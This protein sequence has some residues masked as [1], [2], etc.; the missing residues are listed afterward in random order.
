MARDAPIGAVLVVGGGIGGM[1]AAID[2]ADAGIKVTLVEPRTAIGGRMAQ[3]DKT[4][5]TND[6]AMCIVSPKLVHIGRHPDIEILTGTRLESLSGSAGNFRATLRKIPRYVDLARCTACGDCAK[7]CPV[8]R[9]N[10]YNRFLMPRKA[11][12]K[13]YPQAIPGAYAIEKAG[14][15]PCRLACPAGVSVQ[16]YVK[17]VAEKR[18]DEALAVIRRDNPFPAICGRV[19][20]RPCEESCRRAEVDEAIAIRDLKR[21]VADHEMA[22]GPARL[23]GPARQRKQSVAVV[24]AGPA[25]LTAAYYL[26]QE[27]YRVTV[28]EE[29]GYAGGAMASGIPHYRLP[30]DVLRWE[31][32]AILSTGIQIRYGTKLGR[33]VQLHEIKDEGFNAVFLATGAPRGILLDVD[34][35][36]LDGVLDGLT[37]LAEVNWG[38]KREVGPKVAVIGGGNT[39]I[40][41]ARM[42]LRCGASEVSVLYRRTR[43]EM[44]ADEE[45]IEEAEQEGIHMEYL[46]APVRLTGADGKVTGVE[47]LRTE[48]GEPD[49]SGRRRPVPV[50]GSEHVVPADQVLVAIGQRTDLGMLRDEDTGRLAPNGWIQANP[51]T[52]MTDLPGVFAGGDLLTGPR[53]VIEAVSAGKEAAISIHRYL[54]GESVSRGRGLDKVRA[55]ASV[56]GVA[57]RSRQRPVE[58]EPEERKHALDEVRSGLTLEQAVIEAERCLACGICCECYRCVEACKAGAIDHEDQP[59]EIEIEVGSVILA[60]G[61]EQ[62]DAMRNDEYGYGVARNVVTSLDLERLLSATGPTAGHVERPSDGRVPRRIAWIQCVGSRDQRHDQTYCSGVCCMFATK[63]AIIIKEHDPETELTVF[64]MDIRAHGK[65]FDEY[66]MRARDR[67]GVRYVRSQVSRVDEM[68]D[69]CDLSLSYVD[70]GGRHATEEFD[71][72]V[73]S[74]GL[75]PSAGVREMAGRLGVKTDEHGFCI[76]D[77][78]TPVS[79]S[80]PGVYVCGVF[81]GPKDIPETVAQASGAASFAAGGLAVSRHTLVARQELPPEREVSGEPRVGVLVCRCGIN[82]AGVVD[83]PAVVEHARSLPGVVYVDEALFSCSQDTQER[84]KAAIDQHRLDRFV[85]ASCSPRTHEPVFQQTIR[86]AGLNPF[87]FSMANIRDQCSWVHGSRPEEATDKARDLLRMAVANAVELR[88]L[89]LSAQ[90][91]KPRALVIGGGLAGMTAALQIAD[92]GF[93]V[94][95]VEREAELGG[96]LRRLDSTHDGTSVK[97]RLES[98]VQSVSGHPDITVLRNAEVVTT[99]GS[100]GSF[101]SE[102]MTGPSPTPRTVEHGVTVVAVGAEERRPDQYLYGEDDRVVTQLELERLLAE[103]GFAEAPGRVTMIQCVGSRDAERPY[104]SK[105]CCSQA[106]KNALRLKARFPRARI[107]IIYRDIRAYGLHEHL[108]TEARRQGVTFIRYEPE[109]PPEVVFSREG[110]KTV[111]LGTGGPIQVGQDGVSLVVTALDPALGRPV[112]LESDLVVLSSAIVP[113]DTEDLAEMLKI[114]RT[115][116]GFFLEAHMKLRPVEFETP[117]VF[118]AGLAHG[119]KPVDETIAQAAA[120]ASRAATILSRT[121]LEVGGVVSR[122]EPEKCAACLCCVRACPYDVPRITEDGVALIDEAVCRG[123]GLCAA[124]CPGKAIELQHFRDDQIVAMCRAI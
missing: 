65:G 49:A 101:V 40:D 109:H 96:G 38:R 64:F 42:A 92:Q 15:S 71:L 76:T 90:P 37:F 124:E 89:R 46:V 112:R 30:R 20:T 31:I 74:T 10:E 5:P 85:V 28:L 43:E 9:P 12:F 32:E 17:L 7:V 29:R 113:R 73:L 86:Q 114:Q 47:C 110:V 66:F 105:V 79:T 87:L 13:R 19:C 60:H 121:A 41:A 103:D 97:P 107:T 100:L 44:P 108:Y 120:A 24:G 21:F 23:P 119:P 111:R 81:Q 3:L 70:D 18:F 48:L 55:E 83:V 116:D 104:C 36:Q 77:P 58:L 25:G 95:L 98:L 69:T 45:E 27:G 99:S 115:A 2:L 54:Q 34:G 80:V 102:V 62:F 82:I 50:E 123:C 106:L 4:F 78:F 63:Q 35:A 57:P 16:G 22:Q 75:R 26:R 61:F 6:C 117:G 68:P 1:Q 94:T 53:T 56:E 59:K 88:P 72:V 51:V 67:Y 11:I 91:V 122:V 52:L 118:L 93:P 14:R 8:V 33:E 39:A 84:I